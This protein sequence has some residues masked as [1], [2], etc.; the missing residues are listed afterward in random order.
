[1]G[2]N[3]K[4]G[5]PTRSSTSTGV[6]GAS[7][8]TGIAINIGADGPERSVA[9]ALAETVVSNISASEGI[10][11][12]DS[13]SKCTMLV[14]PIPNKFKTFSRVCIGVLQL[15]SK[16]G[17]GCF[18]ETDEVMAMGASSNLSHLLSS[19]K[20]ILTS[21]M[22]RVFDP[23]FLTTKS[24][25]AGVGYYSSNTTWEVPSSISS[26]AAPM[27][28]HRTGNSGFIVKTDL[29]KTTREIAIQGRVREV[30]RFQ[31]TLEVA[32]KQSVASLAEADTK[33]EMLEKLLEETRTQ[34][35][36]ARQKSPSMSDIIGP[37]EG[38]RSRRNT[39]QRSRQRPSSA[40]ASI[41]SVR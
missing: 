21:G 17:C 10:E 37:T 33:K 28:V 8:S 40:S 9:E 5:P 27:L 13:E 25:E 31:S 26:H 23:T 38:N 20:S 35:T 34:L 36:A 2:P 4:I 41:H 6:L 29:F 3:T 15:T 7:I 16:S 32:W 22:K 19:Y 39:T 14:I 12:F 24:S 30:E 1:M 18:S 11:S